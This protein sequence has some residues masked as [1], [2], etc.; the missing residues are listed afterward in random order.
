MPD[1]AILQQ[2][3]HLVKF[4]ALRTRFRLVTEFVTRQLALPDD[5]SSARTRAS[6]E[7]RP[8]ILQARTFEL[9]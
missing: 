1:E 7:S 9:T 3:Q 4:V 6:V 8:L 5:D 2:L